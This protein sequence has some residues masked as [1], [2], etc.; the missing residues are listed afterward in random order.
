[1]ALTGNTLFAGDSITV[2]LAPFVAVTGGLKRTMAEV[3]RPSAWLLQQVKGT[4]LRSAKNM[5]V[6]IGTN[7]IGGIPASSTIANILG[8]WDH[9]R[10]QGIR[11]FGMTIPPTKGYAGFNAANVPAI[12]ARRK[13]IN[14]ALG[15]A[16]V[17]GRADGLID[18]SAL[19]ADPQ[20]PAKL[21]PS[22]DSGDH[23]H[24][25]KEAMGALLNTA[26]GSL[27]PGGQVPGEPPLATPGLTLVPLES[28][29]TGPLLLLVGVGG[30][31]TYLLTRKRSEWSRSAP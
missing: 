17:A 24:P 22:F 27:S 23:L 6:L 13:A 20:D 14:A 1:V 19:M 25:R 30:I 16:F 4:D 28:S 5:L 21:A 10:S 7:D 3:G 18:L 29:S 31:L 9:A 2:G 26:F 11:V 12:E 8:I 15:E